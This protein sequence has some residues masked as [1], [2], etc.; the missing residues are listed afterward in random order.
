M[1]EDLAHQHIA[2]W[3]RGETVITLDCAGGSLSECTGY[4]EII[5]EYAFLIA[6]RFEESGSGPLPRDRFSQFADGVWDSDS[7]GEYPHMRGMTV[8]QCGVAKSVA[9]AIV[10][11]AYAVSLSADRPGSVVGMSRQPCLDRHRDEVG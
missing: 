2:S 1:F 4:K 3:F 6:K 9:Y 5:I 8:A 11:G 7:I 10:T